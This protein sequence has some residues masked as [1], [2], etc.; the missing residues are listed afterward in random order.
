[1]FYPVCYKQIRMLCK[2]AIGYCISEEWF[3]LDTE[4]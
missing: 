3:H 2:R 1:M 4:N